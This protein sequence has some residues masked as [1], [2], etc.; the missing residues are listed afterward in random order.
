MLSRL[1]NAADN[2]HIKKIEWP[3]DDTIFKHISVFELKAKGNNILK[4]LEII[5][6]EPVE[7]VTDNDKK[8]QLMT[9]YHTDPLSG[10][11]CGTK[12]LYAKIR[13][14]YH[15]K[16]MTRDISK[17]VK[18]CNSCTRNKIKPSNKEKLI[19]TPTPIKPFNIVIVDTI[20]PLPT[21]D[22][23]NKFAVT[24][25]CDLTKYLV[26]I[27]IPDKAASTVAKA[28]FEGFILTYGVMNTIKS[29]LG[30]EYK[31]EIFK[32]LCNILKIKHDF[33][34]AYHHETVGTIERNHRVFNEYLRAYL[35]ETSS[36]W[37]TYLK[38][39]TFHH[40]VTVNSVFDNKIT[41]FELVFG[42]DPVLPQE[43]QTSTID[44]IYNI[45]NYAKE[46]KYRLQKSHNLAKN[47]INK[48]KARNK[49]LYDK[50]ARP[51]NLRVRDMVLVEKQPYEKYKNIYEGPF[52]VQKVDGVNVIILDETKK[53][54]KTIHKNRL[55]KIN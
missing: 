19:I 8:Q 11:H 29:D 18:L 12:K 5:L 33:S 3:K 26:T 13:T 27:A 49:L 6:T 32:E 16:N 28:I 45:D 25:I 55:R 14:K 10:G 43:V 35:N 17:F 7:T 23:G 15:W 48:H 36:D 54:L 41:P 46:M 21:S 53:T 31:N 9:I 2:Q 30:T 22:H 38:Y 1:Q 39:F 47:L 52:Q 50:A 42:K 20:G 44:P 34:T 24:L 40:N 51:L 4:S 37:D